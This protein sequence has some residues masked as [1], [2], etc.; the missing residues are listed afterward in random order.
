MRS[1]DNGIPSG[2]LPPGNGRR[3]PFGFRTGVRSTWVAEAFAVLIFVL[4]TA[5]VV[6]GVVTF[7]PAG[8]WGLVLVMVLLEAAFAAGFGALIHM[9]RQRRK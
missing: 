4:A 9:A 8:Q 1:A 5:L 2:D 7:A 6:Y 3:D